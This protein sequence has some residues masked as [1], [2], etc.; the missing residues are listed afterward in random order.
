[1]KHTDN[2]R[3]QELI[4][5]EMEGLVEELKYV[6]SETINT[7][8]TSKDPVE[9]FC[10]NMW[11][12]INYMD[13]Y[14]KKLL[15][16]EAGIGHIPACGD[17]CSFCC[18]QHVAISTT[19]AIAIVLQMR[20]SGMDPLKKEDVDKVRDLTHMERTAQA[21]ACPMLK[22]QRCSIYK[23]RPAPCRSYFSLD[24]GK[25][26]TGFEMRWHPDKVPSAPI[27]GIP[28]IYGQQISMGTDLV[29]HKLGYQ[30]EQM[31]LADAVYQA[32]DLK[33][34]R[35]WFLREKPFVVPEDDIPYS[36][37]L[38]A[39]GHEAGIVFIGENE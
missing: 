38:D 31:E 3:Y 4:Q 32:Q 6:C 13:E 10:K 2:D 37:I 26:K 39:L 15:K 7:I 36:A 8:N 28:Q 22:N 12:R 21:I 27:L 30:V 5:S 19:E 16:Q 18:Y 20:E 25:C 17:K 9:G 23:T 24:R 14:N 34:L 29:Y 1:M 11:S 35:R 33:I